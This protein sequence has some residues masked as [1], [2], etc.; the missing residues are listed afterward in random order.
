M[1]ETH[2][3]L[4]PSL[5]VRLYLALVLIRE[6]QPDLVAHPTSLQVRD[7][8][9]LRADEPTLMGGSDTAPNPVK[10]LL[11][12]LGSCLA[13]GYTANASARGGL[14]TW[15]G[16]GQGR[17]RRGLLGCRCS[18]LREGIGDTGHAAVR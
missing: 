7:L 8:P 5:H 18:R 11:G 4:R 2:G 10:Q 17:A 1:V 6:R 13:I 16:S 9:P 14:G 3:G 15:I 12:A